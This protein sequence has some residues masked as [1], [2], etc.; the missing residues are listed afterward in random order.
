M[1]STISV[2]GAHLSR[3]FLSPAPPQTH[4]V[5]S[6]QSWLWSHMGH[7]HLWGFRWLWPPRG[8][9]SPILS[10]TKVLPQSK[11]QA[12][13][14]Y[15]YFDSSRTSRKDILKEHQFKIKTLPSR[16]VF[17]LWLTYIPRCLW[18]LMNKKRSAITRINLNMGIC[19]PPESL[20]DSANQKENSTTLHWMF[21][22]ASSLDKSL[23]WESLEHRKASPP[24]AETEEQQH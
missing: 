20:M 24:P 11:T 10:M 6:P 19:C 21:S 17:S 5:G 22:S 2:L 4:P 18:M 15:I 12:W 16:S 23:C 9:A 14:I 7:H 8:F 1:C 13:Q 3:E